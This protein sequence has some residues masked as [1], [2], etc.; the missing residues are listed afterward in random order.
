[1]KCSTHGDAEAVAVCKKCKLLYCGNCVL[2]T[3]GK[4]AACGFPLSSPESQPIEPEREEV[5]IDRSSVKTAPPLGVIG[6]LISIYI[7]PVKAMKMLKE[8]ASITG[9]C[10]NIVISCA[11]VM[12]IP[13]LTIIS[14]FAVA[15]RYAGSVAV[16][17]M[18]TALSLFVMSFIIW[19]VLAIVGSLIHS[20]IVYVV[21][22]ILGGNGSITQQFYITSYISI[23]FV[24]VYYLGILL[25]MILAPVTLLSTTSLLASLT[26]LAI[27]SRIIVLLIS[28]YIIFL[29]VLNIR[30]VYGLKTINAIASFIISAVISAILFVILLLILELI[31]NPSI[32]TQ[33]LNSAGINL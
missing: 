27:I 11:A 10:K 28:L 13:F 4:C 7:E 14:V 31:L 6:A 33:L 17:V 23:A 26:L 16:G 2:S 25:T 20:V 21:A 24:P 32:I 29:E 3:N 19:V 8:N 12:L 9:G 30:E 22:T 18:L 15:A 5:K 1:M